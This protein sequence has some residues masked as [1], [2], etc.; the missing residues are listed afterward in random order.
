MYRG[1]GWSVRGWSAWGSRWRRPYCCPW[2][3]K[4]RRGSRLLS[5]VASAVLRFPDRLTWGKLVCFGVVGAVALSGMAKRHPR[6]ALGVLVLALCDAFVVPRLPIRQKRMSAAVPSAYG[7][8]SGP[9]LDLWPDDASYAPAWGLWTTN[10]GCYYQTEHGRPIADLCIVSP[11]VTSPRM[12]LE[13]WVMDRWLSGAAAETVPVL[14][15]LGFGS[16]A[17]HTSVMQRSTVRI[18]AAWRTGRSRWFAAPT[19]EKSWRWGYRRMLRSRRNSALK[20]GVGFWPVNGRPTQLLIAQKLHVF[21]SS[22]AIDVGAIEHLLG[23]GV[24]PAQ[25]A[26]G[27]AS[28]SSSKYPS[29]F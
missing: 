17:F 23:V 1:V 3:D 13:Q 5:V 27:M 2:Q 19:A 24:G 29:P 6:A 4:Q 8:H 7:A 9:V 16:L 10:F 11:G 14:Q 15:S 12:A 21:Q 28:S 25:G 18:L 26:Q 20:P 22:I